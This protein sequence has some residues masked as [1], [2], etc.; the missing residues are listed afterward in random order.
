[1]WDPEFRIEEEKFKF[2]L[3]IFH[4][5]TIIMVFTFKYGLKN[6]DWRIFLD[7]NWRIFLDENWNILDPCLA[8]TYADEGRI[9]AVENNSYFDNSHATYLCSTH[10]NASYMYHWKK[11]ET[12]FLEK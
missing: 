9:I 6:I 10:V 1:M 2:D 4:W 11:K 8:Y 3:G 12:K 5:F 7:E